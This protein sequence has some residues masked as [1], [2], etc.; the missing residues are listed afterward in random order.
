MSSTKLLQYEKQSRWASRKWIITGNEEAEIAANSLHWCWKCPK[1]IS[2]VS[3]NGGSLQKSAILA[4]S[5][6]EQGSPQ[7]CIVYKKQRK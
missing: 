6:S 3:Q 2:L 1:K 4:V 7:L 5:C